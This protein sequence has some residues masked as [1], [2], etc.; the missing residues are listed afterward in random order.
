MD[1]KRQLGARA[2]GLHEAVDGVSGKRAAALGLKDESIRFV[3]K[4][5]I[6]V[7]FNDFVGTGR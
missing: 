2:N 7:S 4:A 6:G 5:D 1:A 3:P